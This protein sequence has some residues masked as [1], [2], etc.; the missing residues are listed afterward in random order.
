MKIKKNLNFRLGKKLCT[1]RSI[2]PNDVSPAYLKAIKN[3]EYIIGR[4]SC[5]TLSMQKVYVDN[6][7][8]S[9]DQYLNG[10]FVD[11]I[12]IGSAGVQISSGKGE[13]ELAEAAM[14]ILIFGEENRGRGYGKVLVWAGTYLMSLVE[15]ILVFQAG[16]ASSN[17]RSM[18]TFKSCGFQ[19][20]RST[21]GGVM[22]ELRIRD[23]KRPEMVSQVLLE[24]ESDY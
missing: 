24:S 3:D 18:R 23:L 14:G 4:N 10:L 15:K 13:L 12:L 19:V 7:S 8:Q 2:R 11:G 6:V 9:S 20:A 16:I 5:I 22:M 17:E 1:V 21:T